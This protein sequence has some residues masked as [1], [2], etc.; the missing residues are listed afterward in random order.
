MTGSA[1]LGSCSKAG[2]SKLWSQ[3]STILATEDVKKYLQCKVCAPLLP[4]S[5][6]QTI[7]RQLLNTVSDNSLGQWGLKMLLI[8]LSLLKDTVTES[9]AT[10]LYL[11]LQLVLSSENS[12]HLQTTDKVNPSNKYI[13]ISK[14][15]CLS[16]SAAV[17]ASTSVFA[18][19]WMSALSLTWYIRKANYLITQVFNGNT[20]EYK[21][22]H[23]CREL[24]WQIES[25]LLNEWHS[26]K[27]FSLSK[28]NFT[29]TPV[30]FFQTQAIPFNPYKPVCSAQLSHRATATSKEGWIMNYHTG[31]HLSPLAAL[32]ISVELGAW[33]NYFPQKTVWKSNSLQKSWEE[34]C[35][36]LV[37]YTDSAIGLVQGRQ[38]I[39]RSYCRV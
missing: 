9:P 5:W 1:F 38:L 39:Q 32:W 14:I 22:E 7:I 6:M 30:T 15:Y 37:S 13:F 35:S 21:S 25:L 2:A 19:S 4:Q 18:D 28:N 10:N 27:E 8:C 31:N 17:T 34:Y 23:L 33:S 24:L 3:R 26:I 11:T 12:S 20:D 29:R 36:V 16:I